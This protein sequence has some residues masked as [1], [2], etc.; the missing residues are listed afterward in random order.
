[1]EVRPVDLRGLVD[2]AIA[3]AQEHSQTANAVS[4]TIGRL[5]IL[6]GDAVLL[7]Q[8]FTNIIS[9]S[10][11]FSGHRP[12]PQVVIGA[13]QDHT[14]YVR[15]NG[16]G[17]QMQYAEKLFGAFQRLHSQSEFEGTGIG[18]AIVQRIIHRHGGT[19]WAESQPDHGAVFYFTLDSAKGEAQ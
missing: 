14:I 3:L 5:P 18:L 10:I 13:L 8:V 2:R 9:N 11:K 16:V 4:F 7:Q 1:M 15:D 19:I 17:F 12:R 6:E